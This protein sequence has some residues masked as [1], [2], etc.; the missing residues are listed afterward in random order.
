MQP[1]AFSTRK[2][3]HLRLALDEQNQVLRSLSGFDEIQLIHEALPE[4]NFSEVTLTTTCTALGETHTPFF[5]AGMTAGHENAIVINEILASICEKRGWAFGLGSLRRDLEGQAPV[6][7]WAQFRKKFLDL[8]II[9]NLGIL[10]LIRLGTDHVASWIKHAEVNAF[11]IHLNP[12]QELIQPEGGKNFSGGARALRELT[13]KSPVP[14]IVKETGSGISERT[15]K[16]LAECGVQTI[17]VSGLGGTHW[18]RIEGSR[19]GENSLLK[20]IST[21][22]KNWGIPT[23]QSILNTK[24]SVPQSVSI[25]GSGGIRS[26]LDAAKAIALGCARVGYAK[27]ALEAALQGQE[28]LDAWM[29]QMEMELKTALFCTA[30]IS[31]EALRIKEKSTK[32]ISW[33]RLNHS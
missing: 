9:G 33:M 8:K 11:A 20:N 25:Y 5:V 21:T 15:A 28:K 19:S 12:L 27:P 17:D 13:Q 4:L 22:F 16:L 2:T 14:I 10:E 24:N 23:V 3:D 1:D 29:D 7:A 30:S 18:G 26:G 31:P 6:E 32:E